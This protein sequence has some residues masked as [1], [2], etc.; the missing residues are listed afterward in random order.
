[1]NERD[2]QFKGFATLLRQDIFKQLQWLDFGFTPK[3]Q[4]SID[5]AI[6]KLIARRAY[7]LVKHAI[8]SCTLQ[9]ENVGAR[10]NEDYLLSNIPDMTEWPEDE[11]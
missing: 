9:E 3:Q 6:E 11:S 7:D 4:E 10:M 5:R 8:E 1:M 2:T